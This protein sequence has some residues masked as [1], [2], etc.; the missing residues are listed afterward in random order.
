MGFCDEDYKKRYEYLELETQIDNLKKENGNLKQENRDLNEY[1]HNFKSSMPYKLWNK[2]S[3]DPY[4]DE[5][6]KI[7]NIKDIKVALIADQ[8]SYDSYKYEFKVISLTPDN[9]KNQF[10][11]EKPDLFFCES[12]WDGHNFEGMYGPWHE[13]I[14]KDYRVDKENRSVLFEILDYCKN[15]NIPTIFWNK[16]DPTSYNNKIRSF[17]D[18]AKNFDYIFTSAKEVIKHYKKDFNHPNVYSLMFAA[19]PKMFNPLKLSDESKNGV[20]FAGSYY[21]DFP[22]RAELMD[23]I[24]DRIIESGCELC[25]YDR[26]YYEDCRDYPEKYGEYINPPIDYD[27]TPDLYKLYDWCLNFNTIT[28]SSTMFARRI[29]EL[30]LSYTNILTNYSIGVEDIFEDNV[31]IFDKTDEM[32]DFNKNY[33]EKRLNNLYNVLENHT[34]KNRWKQILDTI[35]FEYA[36]DKEDITII[37]K[38]NDLNMLDKVIDNFKHI[39][40]PHKILKILL[41]SDV[42]VEKYDGVEFYTKND[43]IKINSDYWIVSDDVIDETFIKKSILHYQ[44]LNKRISISKGENKFILGV[45]NNIENKIITKLALDSLDFDIDEIEV[46]YI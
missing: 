29:F 41:L 27:A 11:S 42:D 35:G 36:E 18:T 34:Y 17:G 7:K 3:N 13:K 6:S 33:D 20:V 4:A 9:W 2:V 28:N 12:A 37:Y 46:Y 30:A 32:P 31:F 19:Q 38:I 14:F 5:E 23:N 45:E 39:G 24:F 26:H 43:E 10:E 44:Y 40:Y 22:K 16:E 15:N 1:I 21:N 25:I 8:F